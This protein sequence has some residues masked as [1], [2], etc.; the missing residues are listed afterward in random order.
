[1]KAHLYGSLPAKVIWFTRRFGLAELIL[2]PIRKVFAPIVRPFIKPGTFHFNGCDFPYFYHSH[3][4][5]WSN[6]R[7]VEIALASYFLRQYLGRS[8]L[9]V[10][11]VMSR[12]CPVSHQVLD[13]Y[14]RADSVINADIVEFN[15]DKKYDLI[16]SVST[17][18]HIGFDDDADESSANK[19]IQAIA[20]CRRLLANGGRL[21]LTVPLGYNPDLDDL[22]R[23]GKLGESHASFL[24]RT[25][26]CEWSEV[27][28]ATALE[29]RYGSPY[30][31][32]NAV[33][34]AEFE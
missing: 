18:E 2:L 21:V 13:K 28:R 19:I 22:I 16:L 7:C 12:Y 6:E 9:E 3:N 27:P 34:I 26:R 5:T 23:F 29:S 33:M 32:G 25:T 14:E 8:I 15:S 1:M 24:K 4:V 20:S 31:Y 30:P 17:F 11:N 10:G